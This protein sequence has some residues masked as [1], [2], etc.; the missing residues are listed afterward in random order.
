MGAERGFGVTPAFASAAAP[1]RNLD[2]FS[3]PK[4][5]TSL[6]GRLVTQVGKIKKKKPHEYENHI[7]KSWDLIRSHPL[8]ATC[9]LVMQITAC[10]RARTPAGET[11]GAVGSAWCRNWGLNWGSSCSPPP[12]AACP[13]YGEFAGCSRHGRPAH[14]RF[15]C[16]RHFQEIREDVR[17]ET[18]GRGERGIP[19]PPQ[20][21]G[22]IQ[23]L[24]DTPL[25]PSS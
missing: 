22:G 4:P 9:D 17:R 1:R 5:E 12:I 21:W 7:A 19:V 13:A 23:G 6:P 10:L 18:G 14:F 15:S 16:V 8:K 20:G 3:S 24:A 2:L 25:T 11:L